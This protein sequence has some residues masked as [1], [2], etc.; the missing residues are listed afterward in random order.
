MS[1][2]RFS[3]ALCTHNGGRYL[4]EQLDSIGSQTLRPHELIVCDDLS[5]DDTLDILKR[6]SVHAQFPVNINVNPKRLG[7]VKNFESAIAQCSGEFVALSD[8]DDLWMPDKLHKLAGELK[9]TGVLAVFS[10]AE[11]VSAELERLDKSIWQRVGFNQQEQNLVKSNCSF[12]VFLKHHVVTGATLAFKKSLCR[13]ALPIPTSWAHDAWLAIIASAFGRVSAVSE[14]LVA[15]RQHDNNVVGAKTSGLLDDV[16]SA[17]NI[18]RNSWYRSEILRWNELQQR[19]KNS[20]GIFSEYRLLEEKIEH[21]S[22]RAALPKSRWLRIPTIVAE[23]RNRNYT[24]YARNWG[25][26]AIDLLVK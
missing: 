11:V 18:D 19:L 13:Y 26:M 17:L 2:I 20:N 14:R 5:N 24:K 6:F 1:D 7:V 12:S 23:V 15:Y 22:V 10:D 21:I 8:Q 25:S 3:V 9:A 16:I 4:Q